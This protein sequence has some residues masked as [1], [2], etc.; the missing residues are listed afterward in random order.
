MI[1]YLAYIFGLLYFVVY[2]ALAKENI[3]YTMYSGAIF[4]FIAY[5]TY[6]LT[7]MAVIKDWPAKLTVIDLVWGTFVSAATC[8]V[9]YLIINALHLF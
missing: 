2:P 4:G 8:T 1:F 5:G 7:N 3:F 9:A 6:D